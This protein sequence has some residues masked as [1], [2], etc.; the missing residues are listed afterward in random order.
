MLAKIF[1]IYETLHSFISFPEKAMFCYTSSVDFLCY[2]YLCFSLLLS[3]KHWSVISWMLNT[4]KRKNLALKFVMYWF[5]E[6]C[7][8]LPI[9]VSKFNIW[10][11]CLK[12]FS[13]VCFFSFCCI[14]VIEIYKCTSHHNTVIIVLY[15]CI[16][17]VTWHI[18][19]C[20]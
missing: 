17:F 20:K 12:F 6:I 5:C 13:R 14:L 3:W 9:F 19:Y 10:N 7:S 16:T 2:S 18:L 11:L 8:Q 1:S 15:V 4:K